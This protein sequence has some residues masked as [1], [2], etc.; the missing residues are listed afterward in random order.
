[1]VVRFVDIGGIWLS[2]FIILCDHNH[3][4]YHERVYHNQNP[5]ILSKNAQPSYSLNSNW[6]IPENY[7][8]DNNIYYKKGEK[9]F[10]SSVTEGFC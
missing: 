4:F 10:S 8:P 9:I 5:E 3:D 1:M 7:Q 2:L 6:V